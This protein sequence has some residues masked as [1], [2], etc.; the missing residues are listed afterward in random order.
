MKTILFSL[1]LLLTTFAPSSFADDIMAS[2]QICYL[3]NTLG[4]HYYWSGHGPTVKEGTADSQR[5]CR[6]YEPK[7]GCS[8]TSCEKR[9]VDWN[10]GNTPVPRDSDDN[11]QCQN[12]LGCP[13]GQYCF[14]NRCASQNSNGDRNQCRSNFDCGFPTSVCSGGACVRP[15]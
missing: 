1:L 6:R 12:N 2:K 10:C 4:T 8:N 14:K 11:R 7:S 5:M 15:R 9:L 13:A 3:C